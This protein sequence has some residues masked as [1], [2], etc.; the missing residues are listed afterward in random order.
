MASTSSVV[1][2]LSSCPFV[3]LLYIDIYA[4]VCPVLDSSSF[5]ELEFTDHAFP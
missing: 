3:L 4:L 2:R 5:R 1:P